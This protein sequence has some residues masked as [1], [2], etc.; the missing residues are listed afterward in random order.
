MTKHT[1]PEWP[2]VEARY[3]GGKQRPTV[4]TLQP[5]FTT[6]EEGAA[7]GLANMWHSPFSPDYSGHY[8]VDNAKIIRCVDDS[9]VSGFKEFQ[10]DGI[11]RIFMCAEPASPTTFWN[12]V[13]HAQVLH[14]TATL[15]AEL[16]RK[17]KIRP[18][19]LDYQDLLHW[20][21]WSTRRRGGIFVNA[22]EDWPH[23]LFLKD[24]LHELGG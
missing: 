10:L 7:L 14:T 20:G 21:A 16:C 2:F 4:I 6:S 24:V 3:S 9:V 19:Y 18:R 13:E 17:H 22:S 15:V 11:L 12:E 23:E 8:T 5:S 1:S